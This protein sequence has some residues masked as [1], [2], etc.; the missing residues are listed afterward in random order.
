MTETKKNK[1]AIILDGTALADQIKLELR[2]QILKMEKPPGL[3][4]ILVGDNPASEMYVRIKEKVCSQLGIEF[5]KYLCNSKCCGHVNEKEL[6][7]LIKYLNLDPAIN[8]IIVQLPL[9][10]N[11]HAAKVISAIKPEKDVDAFGSKSRLGLIPPTIGAIIELLKST[12]ENLADKNTLLIGKSDIFTK[13]L[14]KYIQQELK[15]KNISISAVADAKAK[16]F[17][18]IVIALGKPKALKKSMIK[19]GAIIIDVGINKLGDKTV[20][21]VDPAA[22][23]IAGW[24]SPVPGGVGPLTVACLMKNLLLLAKNN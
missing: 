9:P 8:G 10:E 4:A 7:E 11:F 20:G 23:N 1:S 3:A 2:R 17:D 18:V 14:D 24:I 22:A 19:P 6:L 12:G 15:I 21:D 16:N 5:H 13:G